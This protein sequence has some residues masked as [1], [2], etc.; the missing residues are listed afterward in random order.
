[1]L[2]RLWDGTRLSGSARLQPLGVP[3]QLPV[4]KF[5]DYSIVRQGSSF[6]GWGSATSRLREI[7][8]RRG[9]ALPKR[10]VARRIIFRNILSAT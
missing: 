6:V 10:A 7:T 1:M 8:E 9:T 2:T 4:N 5:R 3:G